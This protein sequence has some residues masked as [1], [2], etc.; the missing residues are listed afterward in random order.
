MANI[1]TA[2][3]ATNG[4]TSISSDGT[5]ILQLKTGSG[6]GTVGLTLDESQNA[7]LAGNATVSG[8][9]LV[10]GQSAPVYPLVAGTTLATTSG[11]SI[12][13]TSV[14]AWARRITM[15]IRN[16]SSSGISNY[17]IQLGTSAGF[18]TSGYLGTSTRCQAS[19]VSTSQDTAGFKLQFIL[20]T[21][22]ANGFA[23]F[24]SPGDN[25]WYGQGGAGDGTVGNVN[26]FFNGAVTLPGTLDRIR[27]TTV[28][29]TDTFDAGSISFMYE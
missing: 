14:P 18:V 15:F 17:L 23:T 10:A 16:V 24:T 12:E 5:G 22:S 13:N 19:A 26:A 9:L 11:T 6:A 4:G 20:A 1:I 29:G 28:N 27:L 7:A 25:N 3:N 8:T 2:G 21:T